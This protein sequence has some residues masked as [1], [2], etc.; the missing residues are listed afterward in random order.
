MA[1]LIGASGRLVHACSPRS[2][3][4]RG[5][6]GEEG[7]LPL[8]ASVQRLEQLGMQSTAEAEVRPHCNWAIGPQPREASA[9]LYMVVD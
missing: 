7:D 4:R 6:A 8:L 1:A 9:L 3:E 2:G 5:C